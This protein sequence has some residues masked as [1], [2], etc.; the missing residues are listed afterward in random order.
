[1]TAG[2]L[3]VAIILVWLAALLLAIHDGH[4]IFPP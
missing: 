3:G 2:L 1:M 4:D